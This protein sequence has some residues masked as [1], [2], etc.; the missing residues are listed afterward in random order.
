MKKTNS[1]T[2]ELYDAEKRTSKFGLSGPRLNLKD[3]RYL[4]LAKQ[5]EL[6]RT[7]Q[8]EFGVLTTDQL[9]AQC[10]D[11]SLRLKPLAESVFNC[12]VYYTLGYIEL[13]GRGVFQASE[14]E[15]YQ[16]VRN[17][18]DGEKVNVHAWLTLD[19]GEILDFTF[20]TTY[21]IQCNYPNMEGKI[22]AIHPEDLNDR[23]AYKPMLIGEEFIP[24]VKK[25]YLLR[26]LTERKIT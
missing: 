10:L 26:Q 11:F 7:V 13:D 14:D 8:Q 21:A 12:E 9:Y 20:S 2:A 24:I 17:G 5:R 4:G 25:A 18:Y 6:T 15:L 16:L 1:Y 22:M 19:S 23:M 3:V